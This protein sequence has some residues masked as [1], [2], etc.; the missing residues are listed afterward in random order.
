MTYGKEFKS[1][2]DFLAKTIVVSLAK[3]TLFE[4]HYISL[5]RCISL[6]QIAYE[7]GAILGYARGNKIDILNKILSTQDMI[8]DNIIKD[9]RESEKKRLYDF[10][11]EHGKEPHAFADFIYWP[12]LEK[13]T[14]LN[15]DVLF[16][17]SGT[18]TRER[19]Q[20]RISNII[21]KKLGEK[22]L[23]DEAESRIRWFLLKGLVFGGAFPELT[24]KMFKNVY[25]CKKYD[26]ELWNIT[27]SLG[28]ATPIDLSKRIS[29]PTTKWRPPSL[30]K[31]ERIVL[32][33]VAYYTSQYYPELLDPLDLS[34]YLQLVKYKKL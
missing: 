19:S 8:F 25:V 6:Y 30:M 5:A 13:D 11:K 28:F 29:L 15:L 31:Q 3:S 16:K 22:I 26:E 17:P 34:Y 33:T 32:G 2:Q 10:K 12:L 14:G 27:R 18:E 21:Q 1:L 24:A 4:K 7:T 23:I 20:K 9:M